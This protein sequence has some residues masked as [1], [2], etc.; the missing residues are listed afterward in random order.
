MIPAPIR[1]PDS[2]PRRGNL[3]WLRFLTVFTLLLCGF[4]AA[5][6][7]PLGQRA[8]YNYLRANAWISNAILRGLGQDTYLSGVTIRSNQFA[9][10]IRRGCDALEPAWFFCAAVLA[11]PVPWRRK[12]LVLAGGVTIILVLNLVRI[13]SLYFVGMRMPGFFETAHL[14]LWPAAFMLTV[15][16]LWISWIRSS[17]AAEKAIAF[18]RIPGSPE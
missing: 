7:L 3:G 14:E 1:N 2:R 16:L 18:R 9:I 15:L 5:A 13:V 10:A 12:R 17:V 8:F 6:L 11:F 4:Y